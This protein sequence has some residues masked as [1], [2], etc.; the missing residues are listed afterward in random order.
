M[1]AIA[2]V[3]ALT[4]IAIGL[5]FAFAAVGTSIGF[6]ML[7]GKFLEGIARQPEVA[8]VLQVRMFI[9]AG[10]LDAVSIIGVAFAALLMFAN[11]LLGALS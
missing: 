1:E 10:L 4:A 11:P 6:G 8:G 3:Q 9:V 5:I 2:Q 7:G